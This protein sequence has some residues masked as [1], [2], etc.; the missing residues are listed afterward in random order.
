[1]IFISPEG[2]SKAF[3]AAAD[4]YARAEGGG[5]VVNYRF[6]A[7]IFKVLKRLSDAINDKDHI[8]CV[9]RGSAV[10][11]DG[12]STTPITAPSEKQQERM[13]RTAYDVAKIDPK[14]VS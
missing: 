6:F 7:I 10:N 5:I 11:S 2:K 14:L 9:I 8:Y 12:R 1:M 4:G 13:L 3:D